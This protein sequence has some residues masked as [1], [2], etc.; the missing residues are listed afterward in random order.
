MPAKDAFA[1]PV[2]IFDVIKDAFHRGIAFLVLAM[3]IIS[4]SL[5]IINLFPVPVLDGGHLLLLLIEKIR[6]KPLSLK[7]EE[8]LTKLGFSLLMCLMLFV[9]YND[10]ARKGWIDSMRQFIEKIFS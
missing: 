5:A 4:E 7:V 2:V 1:G 6:R 9:F 10:F 8:G 3:A